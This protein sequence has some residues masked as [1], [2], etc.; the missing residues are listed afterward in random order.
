M[1]KRLCHDTALKGSFWK[2]LDHRTASSLESCGTADQTVDGKLGRGRGADHTMPCTLVNCE[3]AT[4]Q[5]DARCADLKQAKRTRERDGERETGGR[6]A[7]TMSN[8]SQDPRTTF[9]RRG[10][11]KGGAGNDERSAHKV[12]EGHGHGRDALLERKAH[13]VL[14]GERE[15]LLEH[16]VRRV[17]GRLNPVEAGMALG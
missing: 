7:Q 9:R 15:L 17:R 4:F 14:D 2:G 3:K 11:Q 5:H 8:G 6:V 10:Y 16:L 12:G 1:S 13:R